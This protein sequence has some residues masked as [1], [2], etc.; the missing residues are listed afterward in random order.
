MDENFTVLINQGPG[1]FSGIKNIFSNS[2]RDGNFKK[3]KLYGFKNEDL[4]A[5]DKE[6]IEKLISK[7]LI[8]K[9]LINPIYLS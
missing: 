5:F 4:K 1:S 9:K 7:N 2:K 8:E 6:N 3:C